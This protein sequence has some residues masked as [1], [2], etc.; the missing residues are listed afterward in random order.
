MALLSGNFKVSEQSKSNILSIL[1]LSAAF[2][3]GIQNYAYTEKFF[4]LFDATYVV[5]LSP[6]LFSAIAAI[7]IVLPVFLR[8]KAD[9][10]NNHSAINI[11]LLFLDI[12]VVAT[13]T[14]VLF[15]SNNIIPG[16]PINGYTLIISVIVLSWLG[17]RAISK[18][19]WI[20][21]ILVSLTRMNLVNNAM[22]FLGFIYMILTFFGILFQIKYVCGS[23]EAL[24][25]SY[26]DTP[27][28]IG[29][30]IRED[31]N[32]IR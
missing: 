24:I 20:A 2:L 25:D 17:I 23:K 29:K 6:T 28:N 4:F 1:A 13:F 22:G 19:I 14:S 10:V 30:N 32:D 12:C 9:I 18:F 3:I 8:G 16:I 15:T 31:F 21:L 11:L 7:F 26:S 5:S 27:K